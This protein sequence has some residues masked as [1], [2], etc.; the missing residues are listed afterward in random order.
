MKRILCFTLLLSLL[1]SLLPGGKAY[2][3]SP[4]GSAS[5]PIAA[6]SAIL[7]E[8]YTGRVLY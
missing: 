2:A 6:P 4:G 5:L 1:L 3:V 8:K 7:M